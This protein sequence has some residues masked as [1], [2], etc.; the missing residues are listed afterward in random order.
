MEKKIFGAMLFLMSLGVALISQSGCDTQ[1]TSEKASEVNRPDGSEGMPEATTEGGGESTSER[2][3]ESTSEGMP[4]S[5]S[6]GMPESTSEGMPENPTEG[7]NE[8]SVAFV[9][10]SDFVKSQLHLLDLKTRAWVQQ[11][12]LALPGDVVL[13]ASM[14]KVFVLGRHLSDTVQDSVTVF[15][16]KTLQQIGQY[17][18]GFKTNPQDIVVVS[19][20]GEEKAYITLYDSPSLLVVDPV[21]GQEKKRIDLG[22]FAEP[23]E[24]ACVEDEDCTDGFGGGSG[25]CGGD[26]FCVSDGLPE[27]TMMYWAQGTLFVMLQRLDRNDGYKPVQSRIIKVDTRSDMVTAQIFPLAVGNPLFYTPDRDGKLLVVQA[28]VLFNERDGGLE[29]FDPVGGTIDGSL[30]ITEAQLGGVLPLDGSLVMAD[31]D[32]GYAVLSN[33]N[34]QQTLVRFRLSQ[35]TVEFPVVA[36]TSLGG[37]TLF[38][39]SLY[40]A[41]KAQKTIR[42]FDAT[43]ANEQNIAPITTGELPPSQI[44][45]VRRE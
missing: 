45:G 13:R 6:E 43:T 11:D 23:S 2:L 10:A 24:K 28:G 17:G 7:A 35:K 36:F 40:L 3:P 41:D 19:E 8:S 31:Q 33:S 16:A 30:L 25:K 12:I 14:G 37:L 18:V 5:T 4:E 21:T 15:D 39:G 22:S 26:Q 34:F 9:L 29:R 32:V 20:A 27:S 42:I 38:E 44:L 1:P